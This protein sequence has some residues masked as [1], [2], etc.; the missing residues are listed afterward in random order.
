MPRQLI[1]VHRRSPLTG[2]VKVWRLPVT[3]E[4]LREFEQPDR[5]LIQDIFPHLSPA[6][7]E[8]IKT[9]YTPHDWAELF[10]CR[11][12]KLS[13]WRCDCSEVE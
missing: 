2:L 5:R 4:Q 11:E 13:P 12:C 7:R 1:A 10:N 8:F 6:A 3:D 9:G